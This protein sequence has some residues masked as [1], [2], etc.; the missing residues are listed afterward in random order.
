MTL[1]RVGCGGA[2][3]RGFEEGLTEERTVVMGSGQVRQILNL[4]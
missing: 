1:E 2:S 4:T 3:L